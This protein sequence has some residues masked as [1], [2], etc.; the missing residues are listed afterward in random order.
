MKRALAI[1]LVPLAVACARSEGAPA[2][3]DAAAVA[4][5]ATRPGAPATAKKVTLLVS[6]DVGGKYAPCG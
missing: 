5:P 6:G 4:S 3:K 1:L 2:A